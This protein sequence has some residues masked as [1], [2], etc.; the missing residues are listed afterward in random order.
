MKRG[1]KLLSVACVGWLMTTTVA[2]AQVNT[3]YGF[4]LGNVS[5]TQLLIT[6]I[7]WALGLLALVALGIILWGGFIWLFSQGN[8]EKIE[9]AKLILRNG[10]IGLLIILAAWGLT[11]FI[12]NLL[13]DFTNAPEVYTTPYSPYESPDGSPFY[14]DHTNPADGD[15]DVPLC[16]I[17][18]AT[19]SYPLNEDTVNSDNFQ[20]TIPQNA[21]TN[22]TGGKTDN[23][24]CTSNIECL[25][26]SCSSSSRC[27]GNQLAGSFAFSESAYAAVF[28]PDADYESN[29]TYH[30]E[31]STDI[32]GIDPSTGAVYNLT[33][34]DAKRIFDF[35]TG[36]TTDNIPPKVDVT[37]VTPYPG[38]SGT[39]ICLNPTLQVS[40]TESLDPASPADTNFWLY[41]A[42]ADGDGVVDAPTDQLDVDPMRSSSIGGNADD[43][44]VT[45]PT[46]Q[47]LANTD[48]GINLYSGDASTTN[49]DGAIYDTC[50]NPLSGNFDDNMTGSPTDD[51]TE[52]TSAGLS[53][54][55]CTCTSGVDTCDVS[56]GSS[57]CTT[58]SATTCTLDAACAATTTGYVGYDYQWIWTTGT[59]AYCTP[60]ITSLA[61]LTPLY[62]SEDKDPTGETGAEDDNKVLASGHYLYPFYDVN[63]YNNISAAGLNC[64][65]TDHHA[66]MSCFIS[67]TSDTSITLRT[68]VASQTGRLSV[69]N[70]VGSD[71]SADVLTISSPYILHT[72]PLTGPVGQF[73]TISGHNFVDYDPADVTTSRGHVYFDGVEAEVQCTDGW[74]DDQI[75]VAVP[76]GFAAD[77]TPNIQVVTAAGKYSNE[78]GFT[79]TDG[80]PGPGIC[81]LH[82]SCSDTGL[83]DVTAVGENFGSSGA[84][85]FSPSDGSMVLGSVSSGNWNVYN[86]TYSS[87]T[88]I[89]NQTPV[90]ATDNYTFFATNSSYY[91]NGLPFDITCS[92]PPTVLEYYQCSATADT[93]YLPNPRGY[94]DSACVNSVAYFAFTNDMNNA[95]VSSDTQV[96]RCNTGSTFDDTL[97]TTPVAGTYD[98]EYLSD[99]YR[100]GDGTH[101]LNGTTDANGDGNIDIYDAYEAYTFTPDVAFSA[102]TYYK[103]VVPTTVTNANGVPLSSEYSW[104]FHVRNDSSN[105][106]ADNLSVQPMNQT[107]TSYLASDA[108]IGNYDIASGSYT[109]RAQP[110]TASCL[111]LNSAGDYNW[112]IANPGTKH[113]LGF[114]DNHTDG[115][116]DYA[117]ADVTDS[118]IIGYETVCLQGEDLDNMGDAIV[119]ADLLDPND[120]THTAIAAS[121]DAFVTVDFGY[122][123]QDSDCYTDTCRD[124]YCDLTTSHCSPDITSFSPDNASGT[125][126]VGPGGCV[127]LSGCYFGP[128]Q[129]NANTCTCTSLR[130]TGETCSVADGSNNCLLADRTTACSLGE[131]TCDLGENCTPSSGSALFIGVDHDIFDGCECTLATA[132]FTSCTVQGEE[133]VDDVVVEHSTCIADGTDTCTASMTAANGTYNAGASGSAGFIPI[134]SASTETEASY[135]DAVVC[136]DTWNNEQVIIQVP[137]NGSVGA[138]DVGIILRN[139]YGL[140]DQ[141]GSEAEDGTTDCTIGS[142]RTACLCRADPS[143]AQEGETTDLFGEGFDILTDLGSSHVS[144]KSSLSRVNSTGT[145]ESWVSGVCSDNIYLDQTACE[146]AGETWVATATAVQNAEVPAGAVSSDAIDTAGVELTGGPSTALKT[147]NAIAFNVSCSSNLDCSTGCCNAGS[148]S[149]A[150]ICNACAN[151][152]DCSSGSCQSVCTNGICAPYITSISPTVGAVGQPV[153]VQ[154]CYF[155][156]YYSPTDYPATYSKVTVDVVE[157]DFACSEAQS[158]SNQQIIITMPDGIFDD[159]SGTCSDAV[160]TTQTVCEA[161]TGNSWTPNATVQ[162]QQ[163]STSG[164]SQFPQ[165]SNTATFT[166]DNSC[167]DVTLP[168]LC[169]ID[170]AYGP[171]SSTY[172]ETLTGNNFYGETDGYCTCSLATLGTCNVSADGISTSCTTSTSTTY[173][174]NPDDAT[175]TETCSDGSGSTAETLN[176]YTAY[177]RTTAH[178]IYTDPT[179]SSITCSIAVGLPSCVISTSETCYPGDSA[180]AVLC[181]S[182]ISNFVALDGSVHYYSAIA[183]N[184]DWTSYSSVTKTG[185]VT[186]VP[187]DSSTGD[188]TAIATTAT[189]TACTSNG[190][191]FPVTCN[192]CS[193]CANSDNN[194]NCNLDYDP[195]FGACT[196]DTT[197]YCRTNTNSCCNNTSCVYD[198][199]VSATTDTGTCAPQPML[200][201]DDAD[202]DNESDSL[203]TYGSTPTDSTDA[204]K[205]TAGTSLGNPDGTIVDSTTTPQP[206]ATNVCANAE[207]KLEFSE[208]ITTANSAATDATQNAFP[209]ND[210][211]VDVTDPTYDPE[212]DLTADDIAPEDINFEPYVRLH[213]VGAADSSSDIDSIALSSDQKTLTLSVNSVLAFNTQYEVV[214]DANPTVSTGKNY[215]YGIVNQSNGV[216]VGCNTDEAALGMC[217]T[218]NHEVE[219]KFTTGTRPYYVTNCVPSYT[220]LEADDQDFIDASYTYTADNQTE[221]FTSTVYANGTD[222]TAHTD[223]DQAIQRIDDGT[224]DGFYWNYAWDPIYSSI[225]DLENAA[226]PVAGILTGGDNGS[227]ACDIAESCTIASGGTSCTTTDHSVTCTTDSPSGVCDSLDSGYTASGCACS[228]SGSCTMSAASGDSVPAE[229]SCDVTIGD[230][231]V[232]CAS[233][234][235]SGVCDSADSGWT[236]G[237]FVEDQASQTVQAD[238]PAVEPPTDLVE[239]TVTGDGSTEQGWGN[240]SST[241]DDLIDSVLVTV[242]NCADPSYLTSYENSSYNFYWAY[243]RGSDPQSTDFLPEFEQVYERANTTAIT[244]AY[245]SAQDFIYEVAFKDATAISNDASSNNDTIAIRVY[246]NDLDGDQTTISDS[247]DPNLWFLINANNTSSTASPTTFDGYQAVSIGSTTYIAATNFDGTTLLPYIFVLAYSNDATTG[248]K[249]VVKALLDAFQFNRNDDLSADCALEKTKIVNDTK[250]V[251]DLGTLAYLLSSYYYND[252]DGNSINDFPSLADGSY[253]AGLTNS[254]WPSWTATLGNVLGQTLATDPTN[255]FYDATTSCPYN[256]PDLAAHE[257]TGTYYDTSGTCWDPVMKDFYGP[258]GSYVYSYQY[259]SASNFALYGNLEYAGD[260]K[261]KSTTTYN[262][263]RYYSDGSTAV[264]SAI[265][266]FSDS[267]CATFNYSVGNSETTDN[268]TYASQFSN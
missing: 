153:T 238:S 263:C 115:S 90:T 74:D 213:R 266:S 66:S 21:V 225:S 50:G 264:S 12:I 214:I 221:D 25:S 152:A 22:P 69:E 157:A 199:A 58:A 126:D 59:E 75:I 155:G 54:A 141:Y 218:T 189:G 207:I 32:Q 112:S 1:L 159:A 165:L 87:Y 131:T 230:Q 105:C 10:L 247:I 145:A 139:Y 233:D 35:S 107:V 219:L 86:E 26:G 4:I 182:T 71:T 183:G 177:D 253:I 172:S 40:F 130:S 55:F 45:S 191:N 18:A 89:T 48:Y 150:E 248:T 237:G 88:V 193:D 244:T 268:A 265:S 179:D 147:S 104:Y 239:V 95:L 8:E 110:S 185:Y 60:D 135:P 255:E 251:N 144:F 158:W 197:G 252:S 204:T 257:T 168:V 116:S 210:N 9:R 176:L 187:D 99:A 106:V 34:G 229:A 76:D 235:T 79:V 44:I 68:P 190:I 136:A 174:V 259:Q 203:E 143:S 246:P 24:G 181:D 162:V 195:S 206:S 81:E 51:F 111:V 16:H 19:F 85:Y 186:D 215:Q 211:R 250:R 119:T 109:Y 27:V 114:G 84:V 53:Q 70:S 226:C 201:I 128:D 236:A 11:Q 192:S 91:S 260:G 154:G 166:E 42:D 261:W 120:A 28:Y 212:I 184:I 46:N 61:P 64:F 148:C 33:S 132:P 37:Q 62:Y 7:N 149:A 234:S 124:T 178:C 209:Y 175:H 47:L 262:P 3:D 138:G 243:C 118:T 161:T 57:S 96:Y 241:L 93:V 173:Y 125:P 258:A 98:P 196:A 94:E 117:T 167:S 170:P 78:E 217:D 123:T 20:V 127:T 163:V 122:C 224:G 29:A 129:T 103:I 6:I 49:F 228:V 38:D 23:Y 80:L 121:D 227:C 151:D 164:G 13:L 72:S 254:V 92:V 146:A 101:L 134:S 63:F 52:S 267:G 77:D 2:F 249:N 223:D 43:T 5:P 216:A 83:N 133:T 194:L 142:D 17:I 113:V 14:V 67:N 205:F 73:V 220:V 256:P 41:Q 137:S 56:V 100:G 222:A 180:T 169:D 15:T 108:C 245:G 188:V 140:S 31:M 200:T 208:P 65:D 30:V 171:Y 231:T 242:R 198:D 202:G 102:N 232:A 39:N 36:T 160:S 156:T 97:C 82:P 240:S